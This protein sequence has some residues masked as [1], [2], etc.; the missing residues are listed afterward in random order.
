MLEHFLQFTDIACL[1]K[2]FLFR[3][4]HYQPLV[5]CLLLCYEQAIE[6]QPD[7][8]DAYCSRG[9]VLTELNRF[10]EALMS[11]NRAVALKPDFAIA[12]SNRGNIL[13][14]LKRFEEALENYNCAISLAPDFVNAYCNRGA[15][16]KEIKR[17]DEALADCDYAISIEPNCHT[18]YW[19]KAFIKLM[20]GDYEE[21][22]MLY[23]WRWKTFLK[24]CVRTFN[25]SFWHGDEPISGK[26]ILIYSE[27]G[28]GDVIQA[29]RYVLML[30]ALGAKVILEVPASLTSIMRTLK[31]DIEVV[32]S[33]SHLPNFD[34]QC[35]VMSLP[36]AFK[37]TVESIP[38]DVPYLFSDIT[39]QKEWQDRLGQKTKKRIGIVCSGSTTHD[40]DSKRSIPLKFMSELLNLPF[41]FHIL[42]K[43]IRPDDAAVLIEFPHVNI[44]HENLMDFSD[45][46]ALIDEMDLVISVDTSVLHLAGAL[47]KT[48]WGMIPWVPDFRWLLDRTD[49]PWYPTATLFRQPELGNWKRV[50]EDV[51][52]RLKINSYEY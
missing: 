12:Y 13:S 14:N 18:V 47:G 8:A 6:L 10:E 52:Q 7:L 1:L 49:S 48:V 3:I 28:L 25:Q 31:G 51:C 46:A 43:E 23:E 39:K 32:E 16:L 11:Y 41:E 33:G 20:L 22:W 9:I 19:N 40:D 26:T 27:Q 38:G 30:N 42:Q 45:T 17:F 29:S 34:F 24:H 36:L 4:A 35:P 21:G 2:S 37:T 5:K 15:A 44:H 50:I